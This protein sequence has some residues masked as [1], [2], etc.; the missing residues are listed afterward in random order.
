MIEVDG[1][2]K[3]NAVVPPGNCS[4]SS[5][6][7]NGEGLLLTAVA[8]RTF[9]VSEEQA[10]CPLHSGVTCL[11]GE[12]SG[13]GPAAECVCDPGYGGVYCSRTEARRPAGQAGRAGR[14]AAGEEGCKGLEELED[15]YLELVKAGLLD[16]LYATDRPGE[17][18]VVARSMVGRDGLDRL[19]ALVLQ[20]HPSA[21]CRSRGSGHDSRVT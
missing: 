5:A 12:C 6:V 4:L 17:T 15:G 3:I 10:E 19:Q 2:Y 11:H 8:Q 18:R 1:Q 14:A 7:F 16:S 20:V 21:T 9:R 13:P